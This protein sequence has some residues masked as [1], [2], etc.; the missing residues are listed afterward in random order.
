MGIVGAGLILQWTFG[1]LKETG[2]I[3]LDRENDPGLT[4]EIR[5]TLEDGDVRVSD[6]HVWRVGQTTYACIV[7]LVARQPQAVAYYKTQLQPHAELAHLTI[8]INRCGD[9]D[10]SEQRAD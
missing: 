2:S 6:L 10:S 9:G 3:L 7:A 4:A 5:Q 8:E 1:L